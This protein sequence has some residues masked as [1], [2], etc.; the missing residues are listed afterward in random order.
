MGFSG[1]MLITVS[2][3]AFEDN[4]V[5][6]GENAGNQFSAC[7]TLYSIDTHLDAASK[8]I[9]GKGE[10]SCNKQ[11]LFSHNVFY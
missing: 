6:K 4:S 8:N 10:I 9:E 5:G 1:N 2:K 3:T 7:L 11:F